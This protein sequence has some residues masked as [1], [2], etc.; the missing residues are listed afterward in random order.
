MS[1]WFY[2]AIA[3]YI[4]AAAALTTAVVNDDEEITR[5]ETRLVLLISLLWG[6]LLPATALF[7]LMDYIVEKFS[8]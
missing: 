4:V 2:I 8:K 1:I 6:I 5:E 3:N 7:M